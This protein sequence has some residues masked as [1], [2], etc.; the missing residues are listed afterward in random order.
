MIRS[1]ILSCALVAVLVAGCGKKKC[2]PAPLDLQANAP[3]AA[4]KAL[5]K[6]VSS[7]QSCAPNRIVLRGTLASAYNQLKVAFAEQA[8]LPYGKPEIKDPSF[9]ATF[10]AP[11]ALG[12]KGS[13]VLTVIGG[14]GCEFGD[15]CVV[16]MGAHDD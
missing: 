4:R 14:D 9:V 16:I 5:E 7:G 6:V 2:E 13:V 11:D 1:A 15:V 12:Q 10:A 3:A 8:W